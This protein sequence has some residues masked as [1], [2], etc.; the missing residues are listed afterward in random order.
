LITLI[1]MDHDDNFI[2][3]HLLLLWFVAFTKTYVKQ[4]VRL[5]Y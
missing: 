5:V 4:G 2:V 1:G 3:S